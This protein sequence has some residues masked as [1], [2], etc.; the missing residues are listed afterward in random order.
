M[1]CKDKSHS[2][3]KLNITRARLATNVRNLIKPQTTVSHSRTVQVRH[4]ER[5]SQKGRNRLKQ[6]QA[7]P[8]QQDLP[9]PRRQV[10]MWWPEKGKADHKD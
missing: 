3:K 2:Y 9:V 1:D 6:G 10:A 7:T 4:W 5:L 8:I